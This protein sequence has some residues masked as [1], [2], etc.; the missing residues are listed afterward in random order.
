MSVLVCLMVNMKKVK[1]QLL[2]LK[3]CQKS[4]ISKQLLFAS[5]TAGME[6]FTRHDDAFIIYNFC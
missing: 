2:T 4:S 3:D 1:N 5:T 6:H